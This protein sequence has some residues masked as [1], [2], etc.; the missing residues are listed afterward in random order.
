MLMI[1]QIFGENWIFIDSQSSKSLDIE[2]ILEDRVFFFIGLNSEF[3]VYLNQILNRETKPN[4]EVVFAQTLTKENRIGVISGLTRVSTQPN[5]SSF[6][7]HNNNNQNF[8]TSQTCKGNTVNG[9]KK[10]IF[11]YDYCKKM[12]HTHDRCW[13]L[14]TK[15]NTIIQV[16]MIGSIDGDS[17]KQF[18]ENKNGSKDLSTIPKRL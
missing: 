1:L 2:H 13:K 3:E 7:V 16:H 5:N 11:F 18:I 4:L 17:Q 12:G 15:P 10:K 6:L 9:T 8:N 14:H